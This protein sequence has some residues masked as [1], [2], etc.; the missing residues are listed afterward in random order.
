MHPLSPARR[1]RQTFMWLGLT[2]SILAFVVVSGDV[3]LEQWIGGHA[4]AVYIFGTACVIAGSCIALFAMIAGTGLAISI[5]F[6]DE[7]SR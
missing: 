1:V 6:R 5:A 4:S 7:P 3:L 2:I